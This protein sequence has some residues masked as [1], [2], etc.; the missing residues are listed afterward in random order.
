[1]KLEKLQA[2]LET[3]YGALD[4]RL[5]SA[6]SLLVRSALA[7]GEDD[8][9]LVARSIACYTLFAVV[10]AILALVVVVSAVLN[11]EEIQEV[12]RSKPSW[13]PCQRSG[14]FLSTATGSPPA[15]HLAGLPVLESES[16]VVRGMA[17]R[18]AITIC[19]AKDYKL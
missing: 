7:F 18:S 15:Q 12:A 4:W 10:P 13:R 3:L 2:Q 5:G 16:H 17:I 9:P 14:A 8:G 19:L 6:P 11:T 1:V